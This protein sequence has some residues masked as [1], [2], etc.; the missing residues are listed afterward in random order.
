MKFGARNQFRGRV[1]GIKKGGVMCQVDLEVDEPG[2][3]S[4]VL[5]LDSLKDLNLKP[6]EKVRA[7]V[8][9]IHVLLVRA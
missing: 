2:A 9:A 5:T 7:I 8:K 3:I 4:S 6:G 1:T